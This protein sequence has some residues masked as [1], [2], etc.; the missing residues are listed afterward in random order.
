MQQ[1]SEPCKEPCLQLMTCM[2]CVPQA[3]ILSGPSLRELTQIS[4]VRYVE[5]FQ[6]FGFN[7]IQNQ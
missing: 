4:T 6:V 3:S 7:L 1:V 2:L 5:M